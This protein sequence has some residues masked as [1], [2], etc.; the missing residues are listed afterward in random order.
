MAKIRFKRGTLAELNAAAAAGQLVEGEPYYV[1]NL[2]TIGIGTST[3]AYMLSAYSAHNH[4]FNY[5][6]ITAKAADSSKLDGYSQSSTGITENTIVRRSTGGD[7]FTRFLRSN[8][9]TQITNAIETDAQ[10]FYRRNNTDDTYVRPVSVELF[11]SFLKLADAGGT[12]NK[13]VAWG[14]LIVTDSTTFTIANQFNFSTTP[15]RASTGVYRM[16]FLVNPASNAY[17]P[18]AS[19]GDVRTYYSNVLGRNIGYVEITIRNQSDGTLRDGGV[20]WVAVF[21]DTTPF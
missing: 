17:M 10:V 20:F 6:G 7:I 1:T 3:T 9:D 8:A 5:L 15:V 19:P 4:D 2:Y 12:A 11:R 13:L 14:T 16:P 18:L 21:R